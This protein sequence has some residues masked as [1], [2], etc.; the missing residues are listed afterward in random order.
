MTQVHLAASGKRNLDR[1]TYNDAGRIELRK[2]PDQA[3]RLHTSSK[4]VA[5]EVFLLMRK[6]TKRRERERESGKKPIGNVPDRKKKK[7][8]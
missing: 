7:T 3:I 8:Q 1:F 4:F 5:T 2:S 6:Y